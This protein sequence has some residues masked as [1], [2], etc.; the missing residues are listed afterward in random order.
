MGGLIAQDVG[1][2]SAEVSR[3]QPT[4][5]PEAIW[6]TGIS[7]HG[8]IPTRISLDRSDINTAE[9]TSEQSGRIGQK[10][11]ECGQDKRRRKS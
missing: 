7:E 11:E 1:A 10:S 3:R 4:K 8:T 5:N 2:V 9:Q 6:T